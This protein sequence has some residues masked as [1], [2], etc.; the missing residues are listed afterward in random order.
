ML[1][2]LRIGQ[3]SHINLSLSLTGPE[4]MHIVVSYAVSISFQ[5][6]SE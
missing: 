6:V 5:S 4:C 3:Y 2:F 1:T